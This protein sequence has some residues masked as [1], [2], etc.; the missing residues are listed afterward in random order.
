MK[1]TNWHNWQRAKVIGAAI[2]CLGAIACAGGLEGDASTPIPSP[3]G[4][5]FFI[6]IAVSFTASFIKHDHRH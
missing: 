2:T 5:I 1:V 4:F 6:S 3:V